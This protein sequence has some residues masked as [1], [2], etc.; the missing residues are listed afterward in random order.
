MSNNKS[1]RHGVAWLFLGGT[2]TQILGFLFGI[3]LARLLAP[4]DFGILVTMQI[5]TGIVGFLAGGGMGQALVRAT[6]VSKADY[7]AVFTLQLGIGVLIY[8][9]L[10][11]IAP[12]FAEWYKTPL[13]ADLL[14]VSALTFI[15]RP[16][17][18]IPGSIL[19]RE[20]RFKD[21]SL[22]AFVVLLISN[23]SSI[24]MA[25]SGLGVW[26]LVIAGLISS[27]TN[28]ILLSPLAKWW[29]GFSLDINRAKEIIRYGMM[30]TTG[31]F[32][33]YLRTQASNF[34]FSRT[35]GPTSLGLYNKAGSLVSIPNAIVTGSVYQVLF[36]AIA[37]EQDNKDK[38][39]YL[40]LK[41]ISLVSLYTWP[42][43]LAI[44]WLALP[45][46]RFLY[47]EKWVDAAP[48]MTLL[49]FIGPFTMLE[50]LAGAVLAAFN[51]LS[52]EIPI[53]IAILFITVTGA[54]IGVPYGLLGITM[55]ASVGI[56]YGAFHLSWLALRCLSL[57]PSRLFM[58]LVPAVL[59]SGIIAIVLGAI[60]YI[61]DLSSWG[62][63]VRYLACMGFSGVVVYISLFLSLPFLVLKEE[64]IKW[65]NKL[66]NYFNAMRPSHRIR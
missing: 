22:V 61:V 8:L 6:E 57:K 63:D 45:G 65:R 54:L 9:C 11:M 64:K 38:A 18:N 37:K 40:F 56:L 50:M 33:V 28:I 25:W 31:D 13:Y 58:A 46:I 32:L 51:W 21:R 4:A 20:M 14:R 16:F 27:I 19:H 12:H 52:K 5:F 15:L 35:L 10:F 26:S 34:I 23:V 17:A 39:Q 2:G 66:I 53:Q 1:I 36:R 47:G 43:F 44:A 29:P 42:M 60:E 55:G 41:S 48:A 49:A 62:G 3:I 30:T 59:I 7:D 24:V